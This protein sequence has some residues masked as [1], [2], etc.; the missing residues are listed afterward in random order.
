MSQFE[1]KHETREN[2]L[3]FVSLELWEASKP[4]WKVS[5]YRWQRVCPLC[6]KY[7]ITDGQG[8]SCCG[9]GFKPD[10]GLCDSPIH[11]SWSCMKSRCGNPK[12]I[13]YKDYGGR[14]ITYCDEWRDFKSFLAWA[15]ANGWQEGLTL[16]RL[17]VDKG[18]S[19]DNCRWAT[20]EQQDNN[21]RNSVYLTFQGQRMT[22]GQLAK[23]MG[24]N[25]S[26][27]LVNAKRGLSGDEILKRI[28]DL[29]N[30]GD[31]RM[32]TKMVDL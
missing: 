4:N 9:K 18:Y 16:D 26:T 10:H 25:K 24:L 13:R 11:N 17:D 3:N 1:P 7:F 20:R 21:K 19:P 27:V 15:T 23:L 31:R 29:R 6:N 14:G 5:K 28:I 2:F 12:D 30:S 8:K 22:C 32:N